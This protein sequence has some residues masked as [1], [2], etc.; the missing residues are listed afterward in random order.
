MCI[1]QSNS[2]CTHASSNPTI[3]VHVHHPVQLYMYTCIIQ[4]NFTCT[5][6]SSNPTLYVHVHHPIP[7]NPTLHVHV[8]NPIQLYMYTCN[9]QSN[10]THK[11]CSFIFSY[12]CLHTDQCLSTHLQM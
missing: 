11:S 10:F 6:A 2:T 5:R 1:I 12:C 8:H 9:I 4:S 7:S 3:H